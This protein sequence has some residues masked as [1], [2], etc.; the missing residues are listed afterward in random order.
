MRPEALDQ[1]AAPTLHALRAG[2]AYSPQAK[3]VLP[4]DTLANHASM[5]G[6][7]TPEKHGVIWNF[8]TPE[9]G[10]VKGPTL[11]SVA[12]EAGLRTAFVTGKFKMD[13]LILPNSVDQLV[14]DPADLNDQQVKERAVEL[15]RG[16]LPQVLFIHFPDVDRAGHESGWMSA[17]QL[18]TLARVDGYVGEI[19]AALEAGGY[20]PQTLLIVTADHGGG[21]DGTHGS[22]LPE[23]TTVPWLAVG[24]GVPAGLSLTAPIMMYDTAA[25]VL[26]ALTLPI[27]EIWDGRPVL[28]I[29]NQP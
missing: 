7:M 24:P 28:P 17:N 20:L 23:D 27:P 5:L 6:G 18:Q 16:G 11:F 8:Y 21:S 9:L 10:K 12:H 26:Y 2:G 22:D 13:H 4:S 15:I 25:T 14:Y 3:A 29:F 19:V 1:A